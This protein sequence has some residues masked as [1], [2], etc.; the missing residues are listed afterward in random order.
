MASEDPTKLK[1]NWEIVSYYYELLLEILQQVYTRYRDTKGRYPNKRY[2]LFLKIAKS[3]LNN[4]TKLQLWSLGTQN[5]Q[6]DLTKLDGVNG[7]MVKTQVLAAWGKMKEVEIKS[8]QSK[9]KKSRSYF[10]SKKGENQMQTRE[11]K[12]TNEQLSYELRDM[13]MDLARSNAALV[14]LRR[15]YDRAETEFPLFNYFRLKRRVKALYAVYCENQD[16]VNY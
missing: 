5:F 13:S 12:K 8:L 9:D 6:Q 7:V 2:R 4:D 14:K 11:G 3:A 1:E 10:K 16:A 15:A